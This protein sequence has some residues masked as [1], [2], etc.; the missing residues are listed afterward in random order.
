MVASAMAAH[1]KPQRRLRVSRPEG[2]YKGLREKLA[3][4]GYTQ[5]KYAA[6]TQRNLRGTWKKWTRY[7]ED[8]KEEPIPFI[9]SQDAADYKAFCQWI[10]DNY[11][12][13]NTHSSLHE[14]WRQLRM[15]YQEHA[16]DRLPKN[17]KDDVNNYIRDLTITY[18]L[19]KT[20]RT[21][22]VTSSDDMYVLRFH[23]WM[24]CKRVYPDEEQRIGFS[25]LLKFAGSTGARP[26]SFLDASVKVPDEDARSTIRDEAIRF[27]GPD[28]EDPTDDDGGEEANFDRG[29]LPPEEE[30]MS[31]LFE[32]ITIMLARVEDRTELVMY[33]TLIHTKGEDRRPQPKTF[34]IHQ[35]KDPLLCPILEMISIGLARNAFAATT[36]RE[37]EHILLARIPKRKDCLIFRWKEDLWEEPVFREPESS[38]CGISSPRP[39]KP[40][41]AATAARYMKRLGLDAGIEATLTHTCIRRGVGNAVN[42]KAP[43]AT[44]NQVMGHSRSKIFQSYINQDVEFDVH[45]AYLD[46]PSDTAVIKAMGNMSLTRDPLAPTKLSRDDARAI[47]QDATVAKLRQQ[48]DAL[49]KEIREVRRDG[50]PCEVLC[51]LRETT[52][53]KLLRKR[54]KLQDHRK[55]KA[56]KRYFLENDT[57]EL[58]REG[59]LSLED[60]DE[61]KPAA[62]TYALEERACIA[63]MLCET[64]RDLYEPGALEQR[65]ELLRTMTKLCRRREIRRRPVAFEPAASQTMQEHSPTV[66]SFPLVCDPRQCLFCI[67]DERPPIAQR[68][69][70]Y[71]RVAKMWDHIEDEH[72]RRFAP[73]ATF[74]CPHPIC[75]KEGVPLDGVLHFKR[76]AQDVHGIKLRLPKVYVLEEST[77]GT[78]ASCDSHSS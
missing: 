43:V 37:P 77:K 41:R 44:R 34:R 4:Q 35:H 1:K 42:H 32:H 23:H 39:S 3:V 10:L 60:E 9:K 40:L 56:R 47:E 49:T 68:M 48:R 64:P 52:R 75:R 61:A 8:V 70:C 2:Y 19:I 78:V 63:R 17:L 16:N 20:P 25:L 26:V 72:L 12:R 28:E 74:P 29:E 65:C 36:V 5:P 69:F 46:E 53:A 27:Y 18:R 58:D 33:L 76:H 45:A 54:K 21:K 24:H 62:T 50:G 11:P 71:S 66:S 15:L 73:D 51:E 38:K 31:V 6:A 13:V 59:D 14:Y 67:G 55:K 57:R 22:P 7:C 30:L